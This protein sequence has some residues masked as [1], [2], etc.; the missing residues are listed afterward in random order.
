MKNSFILILSFVGTLTSYTKSG[1]NICS[2]FVKTSNSVA[3]NGQ[4]FNQVGN[5]FVGDVV[6]VQLVENTFDKLDE[7]ILINHL[8][9][10][11]YSILGVI[12][13]IDKNKKNASIHPLCLRRIDI[14]SIRSSDMIK[15]PSTSGIQSSYTVHTTCRSDVNDFLSITILLPMHL[16]YDEEIDPIDFPL[17]QIVCTI[18]LLPTQR[19]VEDRLY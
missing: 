3:L 19:I 16:Y 9:N 13:S 2:K 7:Y 5:A 1:I 8:A 6:Q 17:D 11:L 18:E 10:K 12:V 15:Q 4:N 14:E